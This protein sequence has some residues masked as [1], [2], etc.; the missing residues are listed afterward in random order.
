MVGNFGMG[1][2]LE[3]FFNDRD[4][5]N[6]F[7][8]D[9]YSEYTKTIMDKE[10]LKLVKD[11]YNEAKV[12]LTKNKELLIEFSELLQNNTIVSNRDLQTIK[13]NT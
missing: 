4:E 6:L 9:K 12:I 1:D 13:I 8:G 5:T 7:A 2:K 11:A 3:V 10:S